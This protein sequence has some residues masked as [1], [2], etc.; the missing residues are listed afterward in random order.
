[1]V[2]AKDYKMIKLRDLLWLHSY[3]FRGLLRVTAYLFLVIMIRAG[4]VKVTEGATITRAIDGDTFVIN[5]HAKLRLAGVDTAESKINAK[6]HR[7]SARL[8]VTELALLSRGKLAYCEAK[9]LEG[10]EVRLFLDKP[11]KDKYRRHLGYFY[12]FVD[13]KE[14]MYNEYILGCGLAEVPSY[15]RGKLKYRLLTLEAEA[16]LENKNKV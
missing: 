14:V 7:D 4:D 16:I 5:G 6:M 1:M 2:T 12:A 13:G 10:Q 15:Y 8:H 3:L 11:S 9:L